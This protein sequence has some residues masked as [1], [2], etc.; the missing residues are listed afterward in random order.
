MGNTLGNIQENKDEVP[1][2]LPTSLSHYDE[3]YKPGWYI[4]H[5]VV[6]RD[7]YHKAIE[8]SRNSIETYE[9]S[10]DDQLSFVDRRKQLAQQKSLESTGKEIHGPVMASM[11]HMIQ[12]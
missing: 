4:T 3:E 10:C 9:D 7:S 12:M 2:R 11:G 6:V 5:E 8:P 1:L